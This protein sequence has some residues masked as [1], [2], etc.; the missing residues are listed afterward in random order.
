VS[1]PTNFE[2]D[3]AKAAAN[4]AKHNV[5]FQYAMRVF[6]DPEFIDSDVS[7]PEDKEMRRNAVGLFDGR[8]L[9]VVFTM[10]GDV[11]R[12]ISARRPNSKEE[13]R[14]GNRLL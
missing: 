5:P 1:S 14:Y 9:V 6:Q 4:V 7:R 2:W 12:I 13:R 8:L 10:R 11:C 3:D